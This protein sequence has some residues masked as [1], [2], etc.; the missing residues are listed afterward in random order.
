MIKKLGVFGAIKKAIAERYKIYTGPI[1]RI[2]AY[3][4]KLND[5]EVKVIKKDIIREENALF[6]DVGFGYSSI[7]HGSILPS[8]EEA[9]GFCNRVIEK[10]EPEIFELLIGDISS[11]KEEAKIIEKVQSD[12]S[13]IYYIPAELKYSHSISSKELKELK[14]TYKEQNKK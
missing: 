14:K 13:C 6:Y 10:M 4:F 7:K 9:S 12:S 2:Y 8:Y 3:D 1:Y 11:S 5:G